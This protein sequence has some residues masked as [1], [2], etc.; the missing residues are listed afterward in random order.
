MSGAPPSKPLGRWTLLGK[1]TTRNEYVLVDIETP[2]NRLSE[3]QRPLTGSLPSDSEIAVSSSHHGLPSRQDHTT[4]A[5][6]TVGILQEYA[7][8][9]QSHAASLK[10]PLSPTPSAMASIRTSHSQDSP[11]P[12]RARVD[13]Q[14]GASVIPRN[15]S[16]SGTIS[17]NTSCSAP[18]PA[19]DPG[20]RCA[21]A[22]SSRGPFVPSEGGENVMLLD[23]D[24]DGDL[25]MSKGWRERWC[26]CP[27]VSSQSSM[28][29]V[30]PLKREGLTTQVYR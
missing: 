12:K 21:L 3:K 22:S 27:D 29:V 9:D 13:G 17:R 15:S 1:D 5:V 4:Y 24:G 14:D 8:Q 10:R 26:R 7:T 25:F 6:G 18:D 20:A 19:G 11:A 2:E 16:Q 28:R 23:G 30:R